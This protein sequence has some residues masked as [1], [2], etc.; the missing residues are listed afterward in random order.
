[1]SL[2]NPGN[3]QSQQRRSWY[4][5]LQRAAGS[6][7][8]TLTTGAGTFMGMNRI[9]ANSAITAVKGSVMAGLRGL[10]LQPVNPIGPFD[11]LSH[12]ENNV[13]KLLGAEQSQAEMAAMDA[14][15]FGPQ[16]AATPDL[17]FGGVNAAAFNPAAEPAAIAVGAGR[18][19]TASGYTP[20]GVIRDVLS[21]PDFQS[22]LVA[23][24]RDEANNIRIKREALDEFGA[25]GTK[26]SP[27]AIDK[28]D[29][30]KRVSTKLVITSIAIT[31]N[32][33][34]SFVL[35]SGSPEYD[36]SATWD[37]TDGS[38][39]L[40]TAKI[41][42]IQRT[43]RIPASDVASGTKPT[44]TLPVVI[45]NDH[46]GVLLKDASQTMEFSEHRS[47]ADAQAMRVDHLGAPVLV[48]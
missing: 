15:G 31:G 4:N 11:N 14:Q 42:G 34:S 25:I 5:V 29:A 20:Y 18:A 35:C 46:V 7:Y 40:N 8:V 32:P 39:A 26:P 16:K 28:L 1:M 33:G 21:T 3:K 13:S 38:T 9:Q 47:I 41:V 23:L 37:D 44:I 24:G 27:T 22:A 43:Y 36:G 12:A 45:V 30:F 19:F 48:K 6:R 2:R 17:P 10:G